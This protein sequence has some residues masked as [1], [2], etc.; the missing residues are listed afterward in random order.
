MQSL[1][2]P[3]FCQSCLQSASPA[4]SPGMEAREESGGAERPGH[5]AFPKPSWEIR[6]K[7]HGARVKTLDQVSA[8]GA[9]A[10]APTQP[11]LRPGAN[12]IIF[13]AL[14]PPV[15]F[16]HECVRARANTWGQPQSP[17][18][19]FAWELLSGD[20]SRPLPGRASLVPAP[21]PNT[22]ASFC[23]GGQWF[24]PGRRDAAP[25]CSGS[26]PFSQALL[27]PMYPPKP[28]I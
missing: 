10:P 11:T 16:A 7:K 6:G 12:P 2:L 21:A 27:S 18:G 22:G 28:P 8:D 3:G 26:V 20:R 9:S 17:P 13:P 1:P 24:C 19:L 23:W 15:A 4:C 14:S 25:L 5:V